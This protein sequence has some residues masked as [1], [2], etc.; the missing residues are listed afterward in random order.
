[1]RNNIIHPDADK[2]EYEIRGIT[3]VAKKIE[4]LGQNIIWENIGDPIAKGEKVADW[5]KKIIAKELAD[6][7]SF[8]YSPTAGLLETRQYISWY[9]KKWEGIEISPD[10]ILFFNGLGDAISIIY[11]Y[12]NKKTR[13]IGPNPAYPTHSSVEATHSGLDYIS[14]NLRPEKNWSPDLKE[15]E[16][17]IKFNSTISGILIIN[18]DNPTG[19]VY[20]QNILEKIVDLAKKYNLF[21]ISDEIYKNLT[22]Q[23]N[24]FISVG[25]IASEKKVPAIIL[26]GFSKEIPWPGSRCG[27]AEFICRKENPIFDRYVQS[28]F[29]AKMLEVCSTTLPQ[30]VLPKIFSDSRYASTLK[31]RTKKYQQKAN[32]ANK[33][34]KENNFIIAPKPAGAFYFSIV[35]K[36]GNAGKQKL[37]IKNKKIEKYIE[38]IIS[39]NTLNLDKKFVYYL[40]A[41]TGICTVPLSSFN[42]KLQ[43][44]RITLLENDLLEF[45]KIIK[46]IDQKIKEFFK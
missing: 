4:K 7:F 15:I 37:K 27:W 31:E 16:N 39:K 44:I 17:K 8:A 43:G 30:K 9:K 12:L 21:V 1:M 18:P 23:Q 45:K 26:R 22:F 41:E 24:K 36:A 34:F 46:I 25:K 6:D 42:S 28:L 38:K 13:I 5:I 19:F 35:F 20:P 32:L 33:I 3:E 2:L 10:D 40:M 11:S 14:Y 29:D